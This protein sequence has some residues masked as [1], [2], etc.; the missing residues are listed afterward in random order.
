MSV[1]QTPLF[2]R[3]PAEVLFDRELSRNDLQVYGTMA[4]ECMRTNLFSLGQVQL[5][6]LAQVDR[7]TLRRC[8]ESLG[9]RGHI[10]RAIGR[11]SR[12]TVYQLNSPVFLANSDASLWARN[13]APV[14]PS[15]GAPVRQRSRRENISARIQ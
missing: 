13:G 4:L 12:R 11:L 10:S 15:N 3:I 14:R 1:P 6:R 8:L 7:R 2:A 9:R 5:A